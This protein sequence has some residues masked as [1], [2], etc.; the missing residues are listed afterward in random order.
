LL[1]ALARLPL[2]TTALAFVSFGIVLV[3]VQVFF[4]EA[5]NGF[6]GL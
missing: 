6:C 5:A 1:R 3:Q 4:L 2:H